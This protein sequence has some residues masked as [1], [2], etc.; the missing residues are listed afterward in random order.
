MTS[1]ELIQHLDAASA[2][3]EPVTVVAAH[4]DDG[5][6]AWAPASRTCAGSVESLYGRCRDFLSRLLNGSAS[7]VF[8]DGPQSR[9][10]GPVADIVQGSSSRSERTV[11]AG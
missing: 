3:D 6:W 2:V 5:Q 8:E 4:P 1:A 11:S 9:S 7:V 10:F